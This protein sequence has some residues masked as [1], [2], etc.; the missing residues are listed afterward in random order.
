MTHIVTVAG[1][2]TSATSTRCHPTLEAGNVSFPNGR[3]AV[4][5]EQ[6]GQTINLL[7]HDIQN[8]ALIRRL[9]DEG[10]ARYCCA[11][12][13]PRSSYRRIHFSDKASQEVEWNA[14]DMG[15]RPLFTPMVIAS[16]TRTL[17]L[18]PER[19]EV[20][21]IWAGQVVRI[22]KGFRLAV[23]SVIWIKPTTFL[24]L[25]RLQLD[26]EMKEQE[27][28]FRVD[29]ETQPFQFVAKLS[30]DLH[31]LLR[32]K[33]EEASRKHIMTHIVTACFALLQRMEREI[34]HDETLA[35]R[36]LEALAELL[37]K[38]ELPHWG[39]DSFRPEEVATNLYPHHLQ[40]HKQGE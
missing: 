9:L 35:D 17:R 33:K 38:E 39:E 7:K 19:D 37:A 5:F 29:A 15:E 22:E 11:V 21:P 3:Y 24:H 12:S 10:A 16:K 1:S 31:R 26:T 13:S 28:K 40:D 27:G 32:Y 25:L 2:E 30:P 18:I 8:A 36:N 14:S 23:G 6:T 4:H 34:D 20:H